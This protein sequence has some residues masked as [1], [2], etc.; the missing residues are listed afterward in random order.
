MKRFK[1]I[2]KT[3]YDFTENVEL[4]PHAF[5]L[6]PREGHDLRIESSRLN[7]FPAAIVR[8]HRD[9]E[10]NSIA[11]ASFKEK[12]ISLTIESEILI[13][14]YDLNPLDF[15]VSEHALNYPFIYQADDKIS[16]SP[17]LINP[18]K[19][20]GKLNGWMES[21]WRSHERIQ[22]FS[23]L[24]RINQRIFQT[25][26]YVKREEEGVQSAEW[27]VASNSGSCRDFASLFMAIAQR[28]GFAV[29]FVSGYIYSGGSPKLSQSTHAWAEVFIPGAGWKGFDPTFG[30]VAGAQHIAT[31]VAR[32]PELVPPISGSFYGSGG[33]SMAVEVWVTEAN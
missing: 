14:K 19:S 9:V 3:R 21:I 26:T 27:T 23:L 24:E 30:T 17:Y 16:L 4:L 12:S 6:R 32:R 5:R 8:W 22:T 20:G 10:G 2:H 25:L 15:V 13:Q 11:I 28:L 29:R 1:I 18:E 7:I 31:A 33:S